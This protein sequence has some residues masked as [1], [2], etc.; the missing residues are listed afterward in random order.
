MPDAEISA[1]VQSFLRDRVESYEQLATL[2][3]LR[4]NADKLW[5]AS[6]VASILGIPESIAEEALR[7]LFEQ[8]LLDMTVVTEEARFRYD[9]TP[10]ELDGLVAKLEKA[11]AEQKTDVLRL[12]TANAIQ[13]L[14]AKALTTFAEAFVLKR[15]REKNG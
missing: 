2:L 7:G 13:R 1:D 14:R 10:A 15:Q 9:P 11:D 8:R 4:S 3:L 6:Q 5:D 12:M